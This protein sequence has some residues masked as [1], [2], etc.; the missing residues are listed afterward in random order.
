M[1]KQTTPPPLFDLRG[2]VLLLL[3]FVI[4]V[5]VGTLTFFAGHNV[6]AAI[7]AG[8]TAASCALV[9]LNRELP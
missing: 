7:L 5:V 9:L 2:A 3:A 6:P 8:L 1:P 4:G